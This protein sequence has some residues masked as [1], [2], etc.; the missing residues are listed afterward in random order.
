M[1]DFSGQILVDSNDEEIKFLNQYKQAIPIEFDEDL[2]SLVEESKSEFMKKMG[3]LEIRR[4]FA[5]NAMQGNMSRCLLENSVMTLAEDHGLDVGVFKTKGG[6]SHLKI[7]TENLVLTLH[8]LGDQD[9]KISRYTRYKKVLSRSNSTFAS[10]HLKNG[11]NSINNIGILFSDIDIGNP[12]TLP[13][14]VYSDNRTYC[15]ICIPR[16]LHTRN[17][18]KLVVPNYN[19]SGSIMEYDFH[20]IRVSESRDTTVSIYTENA[21]EPQQILLKRNDT[22]EIIPKKLNEDI[23]SEDL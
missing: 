11:H 6:S 5:I 21:I 14:G 16:F 17:E 2:I 15:T 23:A 8:T 13:P 9:G 20:D 10:N 7:S 22:N 3:Q 19:Y 12:K 1:N 4:P 18:I